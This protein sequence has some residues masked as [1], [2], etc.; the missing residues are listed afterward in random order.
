M[1]DKTFSCAGVSNLNGVLKVRFA[2]NL[3]RIKTLVRN[4]HTD[5]ELFEFPEADTKA[6]LVDKLLQ[7]TFANPAYMDVVKQT[8]VEKY[9]YII[10]GFEAKKVDKPVESPV[11]MFAGAMVPYGLVQAAAERIVPQR[12][13]GRFAK[14]QVRQAAMMALMAA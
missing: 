7:V 4:G 13:N 3:D 1:T 5:I 9:G 12:I 11:Q 14:K 2:N 6:E 8:A 10:P